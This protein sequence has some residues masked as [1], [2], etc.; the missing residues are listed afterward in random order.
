MKRGQLIVI[1]GFS[2]VGKGTLIEMLKMCFPDEYRLSVSATTRA[3]RKGEI[4]GVNYHYISKEE[5]QGMIDRD[6]FLEYAQYV[7]NSYGTPRKPVEEWLS[8]GKDVILEIE[9]QGA[10]QVK[11][12]CPQALLL[13]IAPPS[14]KALQERLIGRNT[15]K[16]EDVAKR[17]KA[18]MKEVREM[19]QY[20]Y[21]LVNDS[22]FECMCQIRN[23]LQMNRL[24]AEAQKD[25]IAALREDIERFQEEN[26]L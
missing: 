8:E 26:T 17:L 6:E 3:P 25:L 20:D 11:A 23:L 10:L 15:E 19:D 18:T 2:G 24:K 22:R 21:I 7:D 16:P 1:S 9:P 14:M 12:K 4:P 13:F 5:F